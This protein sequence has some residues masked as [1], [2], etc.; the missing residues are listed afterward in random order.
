MSESYIVR[1]QLTIF[2]SDHL[3]SHFMLK[4]ANFK[5]K[6]D[7][8]YSNALFIESY[9]LGG[10]TLNSSGPISVSN[11]TTRGSDGPTLGLDET[12]QVQD[13]YSLS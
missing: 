3:S 2:L 7:N 11:W 5:L 13:E 6:W 9:K 4:K 8:L 1:C 12:Y 10:Q